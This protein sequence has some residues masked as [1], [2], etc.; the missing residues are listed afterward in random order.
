[1]T[2]RGGWGGRGRPGEGWWEE[3]KEKRELERHF[4][5]WATSVQPSLP[6]A[7]SPSVQCRG[8]L[9]S[10]PAVPSS[11]KRQSPG[12]PRVRSRWWG[13]GRPPPPR[14]SISALEPPGS[15]QRACVGV[16]GHPDQFSKLWPAKPFLLWFPGERKAICKT[17]RQPAV[18]CSD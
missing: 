4:I 13:S 3:R 17:G 15:E 16:G 2:G 10:S 12:H 8:Q 18:D 6:L 9:P 14:A 11:V 7:P 5:S 1:M